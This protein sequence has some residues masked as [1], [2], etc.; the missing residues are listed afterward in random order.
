MGSIMLHMHIYVLSTFM[1]D[2]VAFYSHHST[3]HIHRHIMSYITLQQTNI[4]MGSI[5]GPCVDDLPIKNVG[6]K[7]R[8]LSFLYF[9]K[10]AVTVYNG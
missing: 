6:F 1:V 3:T 9:P 5:N 8:K 4:T 7:V 10:R 2:H